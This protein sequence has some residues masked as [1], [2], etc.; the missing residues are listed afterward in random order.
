MA[1]E[2]G[3]I[4]LPTGEGAGLQKIHRQRYTHSSRQVPIYLQA[5]LVRIDR[6]CGLYV[7]TEA[8]PGDHCA[9]AHANSTG[10]RGRS[11]GDRECCLVDNDNNDNKINDTDMI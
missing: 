7:K 11:E 8:D 2:E 3:C 9:A 1:T 4:K 10:K 6:H 5:W